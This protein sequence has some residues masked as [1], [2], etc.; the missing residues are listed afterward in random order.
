MAKQ[1]LADSVVNNSKPLRHPIRKAHQEALDT[2]K[3]RQE[4]I[5][6]NGGTLV[7]YL[8]H[9]GKEGMRLY[10][11]DVAGLAVALGRVRQWNSEKT[12]EPALTRQDVFEA[13]MFTRP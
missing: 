13:V 10:A 11:E 8:A 5:R 2:L 6:A 9:H 7:A 3:L 1:R 12:N 4:L